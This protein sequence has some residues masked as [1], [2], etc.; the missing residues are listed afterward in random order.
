[1]PIFRKKDSDGPY[2]QWGNRG[3]KYHYISG[4]KRSRE[5][6]YQKAA[7]QAGAAHAHGYVGK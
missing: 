1:M 5:I 2:Y 6:A 7:R 3:A 4:N